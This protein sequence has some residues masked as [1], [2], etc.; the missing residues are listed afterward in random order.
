M[1]RLII[2]LFIIIANFSQAYASS[3]IGDKISLSLPDITNSRFYDEDDFDKKPLTIFAFIENN[4]LPCLQELVF[5]RKQS[6]NYQNIDFV[7]IGTSLR[8]E[9]ISFLKRAKINYD[10]FTILNVLNNKNPQ[11]LL[12]RFGNKTYALPF[13]VAIKKDLTICYANIG[14]IDHRKIRAIKSKCS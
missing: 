7:L 14:K 3:K 10:D 5:L 8:A 6:K 11:K 1:I 2:S 12:E 4:C 13:S 9:T